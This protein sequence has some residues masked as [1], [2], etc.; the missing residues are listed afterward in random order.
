[1]S[2][3]GR[4]RLAGV[5]VTSLVGMLVALGVP[6][7]SAYAGSGGPGGGGAAARELADRYG[8]VVMLR[9]FTPPCGDGEPYVP[10]QVQ[11]LLGNPEIALRQVGN[12]DPVMRWAPTAKDLYGLG[13]GTYLDLPGDALSPGCLYARDNA[14]YTPLS[15][16][17]V[18]AHVVQQANRPGY[19]AVQYW[20]YW[21]FND[22]ND[23]HES[24]WEFVQVLFRAD[25]VE[26]ALA[27]EPVS[28]GYAQH[29]GGETHA[30]SSPDLRRE[31]THPV[32]YSSQGSHASYFAPALYLGRGASEGFGCDNT[33]EPSTRVVPKVVLL[34][35]RPSGPDDR[36]AWLAFGGRW[37][38]RHGGP[39]NGPDGPAGK[40]RWTK[41]VDW[42]DNLRPSSFEIPGGSAAP[43]PVI[44]T[45]CTVVGQG[46]VLYVRFAASPG[47][48]LGFLGAVVL[49]VVLLLR[50]TSWESVPPLPL[51]A[52][53]RAGEILRAAGRLYRRHVLAMLVVGVLAVPVGVLALLDV[54]ALQ[55][56]PVV[57]TAVQV[58]TERGD[59]GN[60]LALS[61]LVATTFW[62]ITVV[63][64]SAAVAHLFGGSTG[65]SPDRRRGVAE[66]LAAVRAVL[67]RWR[68][69]ASAFLPAALGI[70]LL[71]VVGFGVP[72]ALWLTVRYQFVG[73][74]VLLD[75]LSG[76]AAR[77][78][79]SALVH[80][81]WWHTAM[82]AVL[83]WGGVH[84]V[85]VLLGLLLLVL[86]TS[87]PLWT[88]TVAV[89]V[90]QVVLTPLGALAITLLY[91]DA[92]AEHEE[93]ARPE[94]QLADA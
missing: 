85:G 92:V 91:G 52:R 22:W 83:L 15:K 19:V 61:T 30:W 10:M 90:A 39:N 71:S 59:T 3:G 79:S 50:R 29:E 11:P 68:D 47:W 69:L 76:A 18:Y 28:V 16:A 26:Q 21:Y 34:P 43:P 42:Q 46:S 77:R 53:R 27:T 45:F 6:G 66:G 78:R 63:L 82:F 36:F 86:F 7:P 2:R 58:S 32:V 17:A 49:L 72:L 25:S 70:A 1:M 33:Q 24:D 88:I 5:L 54:A 48:V 80:R 87:L 14:R 55:H 35:D 4:R 8:P 89:L 37:G 93:Q 74:A 31:G 38:E 56:V 73:Q 67:A 62:P 60:R 65:A 75:G 40:P 64:V 44:G 20:L 23:K 12:G 94:P 51:I 41:P 81:R 84:L 57:D 9:Q 13:S